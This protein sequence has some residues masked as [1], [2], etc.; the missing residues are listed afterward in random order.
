MIFFRQNI[1]NLSKM[2]LWQRIHLPY[3]MGAQWLYLGAA[4]S[5]VTV[6][7]FLSKTHLSR[8]STGSTQEDKTI[9]N[10][11]RLLCV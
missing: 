11:I 2:S 5:S 9:F 7:W 10:I 1:G 6:L 4:G 8:L 3:S